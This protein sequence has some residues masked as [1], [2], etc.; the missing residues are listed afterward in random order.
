MHDDLRLLRLVRMQKMAKKMPQVMVIMEGFAAAITSSAYIMLLL[1]IVFYVF[2]VAGWYFFALNDPWHFRNVPISLV[3][4]FRAATLEDW[5]DI[6]YINIYGCKAFQGGIYISKD[7]P[8]YA[9]TEG[10]YKCNYPRPNPII[11]TTYWVLFVLVTGLVALS[12]FVGAVTVSMAEKMDEM[13]DR[14][15][16]ESRLNRDKM[17]LQRINAKYLDPETAN[18]KDKAYLIKEIGRASCRERV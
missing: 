17:A 11:A 9:T 15:A 8:E 1:A 16:E 10:L 5:T 3:S 13:K 4:L 12:L 6:M 7:R 2:A 14:K 18:K